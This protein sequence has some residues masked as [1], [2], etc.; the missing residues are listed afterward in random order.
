MFKLTNKKALITG[1]SRGIGAN[2]AKFFADSGAEVIITG[3]NEEKLKEVS[4]SIGSNCSYV[5]ANL[6]NEAEIEHLISNYCTDLDILV[7]NAGVTK[8]NLLLRM[9]SEDWQQ[10]ID[11][12]LTA[13]FKLIKGTIRGMI[14]KRSGRIINLS[15]V[16][17]SSGNPG[18][19]NYCA[20]KAGLVGLTKSIALEIA[21]R[22]VTV[23]CISPGFIQTDMTDKLTEAQIDQITKNIPSGKM[24]NP[25][26]IASAALFLASD[27]A[28]YITGQNI[29]INGGLYLAN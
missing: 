25:N 2:I 20:S 21:A 13:S 10:V 14:K 5:V 15:S 23:N 9:K 27:E 7:N 22:G 1:G 3:T 28:G 12:N 11:V 24:G 16:V 6:S 8:D 26:D 4:T 17:G 29:H 18:Q 19:A